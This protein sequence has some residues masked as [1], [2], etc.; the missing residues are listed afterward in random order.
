M[1]PAPPAR[2]LPTLVCAALAMAALGLSACG[3]DGA[4]TAESTAAKAFRTASAKHSADTCPPQVGALVKALDSMRRQ[5]A[6][7]LS[8]EQYA[9]E[10]KDLRKRYAQIPV[11]RLPLGCLRSKGTPAE[12]ALNKYIDGVNAWGRMPRRRRLRHRGDRTGAA[13]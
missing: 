4:A 9:A 7:G 13:A 11:E 8:Y 6:V 10:V 3:D 12:Q 1:R 5:L 2:R